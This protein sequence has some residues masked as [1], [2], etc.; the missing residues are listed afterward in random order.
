[1]PTVIIYWSP[2]RT[3]EQKQKVVE[4]IT[5]VMVEEANARREDI[6]IIFQNIEAGDAG[7]GGVMLSPPSLNETAED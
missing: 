5:D 2:G 3:A 6:L 4:R 1:M 7:R